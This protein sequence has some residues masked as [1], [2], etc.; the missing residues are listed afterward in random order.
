MQAASYEVVFVL[1]V[2]AACTLTSVLAVTAATYR[3]LSRDHCLRAGLLL[4]RTD[5]RVGSVAWFQAELEQVGPSSF[6][7]HACRLDP[8]L[9]ACYASEHSSVAY[10]PS[11][12]GAGLGGPAEM[13]EGLVMMRSAGAAAS[14]VGMAQGVRQAPG[15]AGAGRRQ[16]RP[17]VAAAQLLARPAAP[18]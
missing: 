8:V 14:E 3:I 15:G 16:W 6:P 1:L 2:A 17:R 13:A 4:P 7:A 18:G 11:R 5:R 12:P 10:N 9:T